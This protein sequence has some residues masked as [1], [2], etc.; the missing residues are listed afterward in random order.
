MYPSVTLFYFI[1][2]NYGDYRR[3]ENANLTGPL[4]ADILTYSALQGL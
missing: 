3:F 2:F 1:K 4:P